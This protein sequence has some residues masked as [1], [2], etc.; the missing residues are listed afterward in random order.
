MLSAW[1]VYRGASWKVS[2]GLAFFM[3]LIFHRNI[4]IMDLGD[5]FF[6]ILLLWH[7]LILGGEGKSFKWVKRAFIFQI[8]V[9]YLQNG[10]FRIVPIW[11]EWGTALNLLWSFPGLAREWVLPFG[12][13]WNFEIL[14]RITPFFEIGFGLLLFTP[15]KLFAVIFFLFYQ[16]V[17]TATFNVGFYHPVMFCWWLIFLSLDNR[18]TGDKKWGI[19]AVLALLWC[20]S[21]AVQSVVYL[22]GLRFPKKLDQVLMVYYMRQHWSMF[23]DAR[24]RIPLYSFNCYREANEIPCGPQIDYFTHREKWEEPHM[25]VL[26]KLALRP[27]LFFLRQP[28]VKHLCQ[29]QPSADEIKI[30]LRIKEIDS[31]SL[32]VKGYTAVD[33]EVDPHCPGKVAR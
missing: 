14:S 21:I 29:I 22:S 30:H 13:D 18:N 32:A 28:L 3:S 24:D 5:T 10:I 6:V 11:T 8:A 25:N 15:W 19:P 33:F 4:L 20:F 17:A 26:D 27:H 16:I 7:S 23:A 12:Q 1:G 31:Q 9:M 2:L